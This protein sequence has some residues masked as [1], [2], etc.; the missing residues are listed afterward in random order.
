MCRVTRLLRPTDRLIR[1]LLAPALIFI[2]T[3]IDRNYQTD[4]WHHLARGRVFV[5]E[6]VLL[7]TDRFTFTVT[8]QPF[9]DVNWGWQIVFYYLYRAGGLPLVQTANSA[10]LALM[11]GLLFALTRRYCGSSV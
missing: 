11:M 1:T 3:S 6:G 5:E 8:D 10:V 4:L 9:R 2:A 7:D